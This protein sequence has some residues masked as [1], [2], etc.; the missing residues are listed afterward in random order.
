MKIPI[1][2]AFLS[3]SALPSIYA[4]IQTSGT[5]IADR[6]GGWSID[7]KFTDNG[8][9]VC[10]DAYAHQDD[11]KEWRFKCNDGYDV[12]LSE[13]GDHI[14]YTSLGNTVQWTQRAKMELEDGYGACHDKRGL[15]ARKGFCTKVRTY[16]WDTKRDCQL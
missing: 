1:W 8:V 14:T 3:L 2:I 11:Q 4:C 9:A 5:I 13:K 15:E 10:D 16:T 12:I 6:I 7:M